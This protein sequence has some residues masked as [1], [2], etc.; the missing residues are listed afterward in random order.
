[1]NVVCVWCGVVAW[2]VDVDCVLLG[3]RLCLVP[4]VR[5]VLRLCCLSLR[6]AEG[7]SISLHTSSS[8]SSRLMG[9][10]AMPCCAMLCY[11]GYMCGVTVRTVD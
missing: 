5:P 6:R 4:R 11:A 7:L 1:M 9:G 10:D 3:S 2:Q 8:S